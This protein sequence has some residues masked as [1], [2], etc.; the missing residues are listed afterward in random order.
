M[1]TVT[2]LVKY[3]S[4]NFFEDEEIVEEVKNMNKT[5]YHEVLEEGIKKNKIANTRA[6]LD[7]LDDETI[8]ERIQLDIE[9]VK[10]LRKEAESNR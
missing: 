5:L 1:N 2:Y 9:K 3:L 10:E 7:I 4:D 6:L 8:A